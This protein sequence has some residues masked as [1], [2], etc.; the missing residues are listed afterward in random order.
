[1]AN[2]SQD[3]RPSDGYY[4]IVYAGGAYRT[5]RFKTTKDGPYR[6][7]TTISFKEMGE[8]IGCGNVNPDGSVYFWRKF[9]AVTTRERMERIRYA[10]RKVIESPREFQLAFAMKEG[11]CARCGRKLIVPASIH[12]GLGPECAK[13][14]SGWRKADNQEAFAGM[15][16]AA[17]PK[18]EAH[19]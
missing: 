16:T 6:G 8:Y 2:N 19:A 11:N 7:R 17:T 9:A 18:P 13:R 4:T 15:R 5:M 10:V 1:M 14:R 12:N 3:S